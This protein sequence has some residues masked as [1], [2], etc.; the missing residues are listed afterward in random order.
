M[1]K[2]N[3]TEKGLEI[4]H[5][6]GAE[7]LKE[8]L[9]EDDLF[10]PLLSAFVDDFN[11]RIFDDTVDEIKQEATEEAWKK[12]QPN[13]DDS[14]IFVRAFSAYQKQQQWTYKTGQMQSEGRLLSVPEV[15]PF[16]PAQEV[17]QYVL[18]GVIGLNFS[19]RHAVRGALSRRG[20]ERFECVSTRQEAAAI[21][22][23]Y[24]VNVVQE[25]ESYTSKVRKEQPKFSYVYDGLKRDVYVSGDLH[26]DF[27]MTQLKSPVGVV[28]S[29]VGSE[30]EF[31]PEAGI[32]VA[33]YHSVEP[34]ITAAMLEDCIGI[35][36][37]DELKK[38]LS[39]FQEK[40][41]QLLSHDE[42]THISDPYSRAPFADYGTG[43]VDFIVDWIEEV[44]KD[45]VKGRGALTNSPYLPQ[46]S[47]NF[48]ILHHEDGLLFRNGDENE[49]GEGIVV[50]RENYAD[51]FYVLLR[52]AAQGLGRTGVIQHLDLVQGVQKLVNN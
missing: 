29:P 18:S 27:R 17:D 51:M 50:K 1:S 26:G 3:F 38:V 28:I 15:Q 11:F 14:I 35:G 2:Y 16:L 47:T 32:T 30:V 12:L 19:R 49:T 7:K 39:E 33:G 37:K 22:G 23:A 42:V 52:Q 20:H 31:S 40:L 24:A 46:S 44:L 48:Q 25:E 34:D 45:E 4:A 8:R 36:G 43:E 9:L 10:Q 6:L 41:V 13:L 21:I 5:D